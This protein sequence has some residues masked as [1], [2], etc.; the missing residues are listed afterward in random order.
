MKITK[1]KKSPPS[2]SLAVGF[3]QKLGSLKFD[4]RFRACRQMTL[5]YNS[6]RGSRDMSCWTCRVPWRTN[7]T[8]RRFLAIAEIAGSRWA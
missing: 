2:F 7:Y 3:F 6:D 1:R 4:P 8:T 5:A